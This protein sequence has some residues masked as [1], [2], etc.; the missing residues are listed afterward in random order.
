MFYGKINNLK[1]VVYNYAQQH[2]SISVAWWP[3]GSRGLL[4]ISRL[5]V[6]I[7]VTAPSSASLSKLF[8]RM[9]LCHQSV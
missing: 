2:T 8:A 6:Q 1:N 3:S 7:L 4:A 9:C 5:R